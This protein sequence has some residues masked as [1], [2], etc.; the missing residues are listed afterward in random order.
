MSTVFNTLLIFLCLADL[1]FL[2]CSFVISLEVTLE[3]RGQQLIFSWPPVQLSLPSSV[4]LVL[5][6]LCHLALTTSVLM[7]ASCTIERH[8][9]FSGDWGR[10][11]SNDV[12]TGSLSASRLPRK[13]YRDRGEETDHLLRP[14]HHPL[15]R[16]PQHSQVSPRHKSAD[17]IKIKRRLR[18]ISVTAT[19]FELQK[20]PIYLRLTGSWF[21]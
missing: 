8:Q 12:M 6:C 16:D 20:D 10:N 14:P 5:E 13:A 1:L 9:V 7:T 15:G 17:Q 4:Y 3:V 18:F 21:L 2:L 11:W 19:G